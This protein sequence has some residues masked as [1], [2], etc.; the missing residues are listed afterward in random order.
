MSIVVKLAELSE[1]LGVYVIYEY[2]L[3]MDPPKNVSCSRRESYRIT[4]EG[5]KNIYLPTFEQVMALT[6]EDF[7][8]DDHR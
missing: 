7:V 1:K 3:W 5:Y 6:V 8:H 4:A 2:N